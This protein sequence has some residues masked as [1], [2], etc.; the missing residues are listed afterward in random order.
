M[1]VSKS[2]VQG[3]MNSRVSLLW[4]GILLVV[5]ADPEPEPRPRPKP[6][7]T[8]DFVVHVPAGEK[9]AAAIAEKHGFQFRGKVSLFT[10]FSIKFIFLN[11]QIHFE[12]TTITCS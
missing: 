12:K 5:S 3:M 10:F 1:R 8:Q 11:L 2:L 4:L 6:I 7:Y 9:V